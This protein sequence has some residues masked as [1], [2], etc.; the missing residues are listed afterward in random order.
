MYRVFCVLA[1]RSKLQYPH[2]QEAQERLWE[3]SE[4]LCSL[5]AETYLGEAKGKTDVPE[6]DPVEQ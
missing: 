1:N 6:L 4:D 5:D 3:I 2:D